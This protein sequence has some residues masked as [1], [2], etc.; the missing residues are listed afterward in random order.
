MADLILH[1]GMTKTGSTALFSFLLA[2]SAKLEERGFI[3]PVFPEADPV[4]PLGRNASA[5]IRKNQHAHGR[6]TID[7]RDMQVIDAYLEK[8]ETL[9][10]GP[11]TVVLRNESAFG[12]LRQWDEVVCLARGLGFERVRILVYLRR[13]DQHLTSFWKESSDIGFMGESWEECLERAVKRHLYDFDVRLGFIEEALPKEDIVVRSY[14]GSALKRSGGLF[15][16][17]CGAMGIAWDES[18]RIPS[19]GTNDSRSYDMAEALSRLRREE[20][21]SKFVYTGP[22]AW[23]AKAISRAEPDPKGMSCFTPDEARA[24]NERFAASIQAV[25]E[26]YFDGEPLFDDD[27]DH[28]VWV[29]DEERIQRYVNTLRPYARLGAFADDKLGFAKPLFSRLK[30]AVLRRQPSASRS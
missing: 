14:S 5:I 21:S 17:F 27:Y 28:P 3:F 13:P 10:K 19:L 1:I 25:S 11:G 4:V 7:S 18:F 12:A 6:C 23:K 20:G 22:L 16:D 15:R 8:L 30:A 26:R 24:F 9:A 2:N 29:P